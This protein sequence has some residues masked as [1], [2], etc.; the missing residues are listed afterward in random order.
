ML[1]TPWPPSCAHTGSS[2][3]VLATSSRLVIMIMQT[4]V[5]SSR[6]LTR[7]EHPA[8]SRD[9]YGSVSDCCGDHVQRA[10]QPEPDD[11][12]AQPEA[13]GGDRDRADRGH[14]VDHDRRDG[15]RHQTG[16]ALDRTIESGDPFQRCSDRL[17]HQRNRGVLGV[18]AGAPGSTTDRHHDQ[19]HGQREPAEQVSD[20]DHA[21]RD[22]AGQVRDDAHPTLAET[23]DDRSR[24]GLDDHVGGELAGRDQTGLGRR[25]GSDQD[26]P[27]DRDR[28][29]PGTDA[30]DRVDD[31]QGDQWCLALHPDSS[32]PCASGTGKIW[33]CAV[34]SR[35]SA[36]GADS[37][38]CCR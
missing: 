8:R 1:V 9:R 32:P 33:N 27:G 16:T 2:T 18:V 11:H 29:D 19:Q 38:S 20:R 36:A 17:R 15:R 21:D 25:P 14:G 12:G 24:Q 37:G 22:H 30:G 13:S 6:S 28:R 34:T 26:E 3:V 35:A 4:R 10:G 7:N 5:N 23:I 31:Q